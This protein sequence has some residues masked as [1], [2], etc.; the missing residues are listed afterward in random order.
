MF[1]AMKMIRN[2][3][4]VSSLLRNA[5][6]LLLGFC[7][8]GCDSDSNQSPTGNGS[9]I[10]P[11]K[12]G[13]MFIF[14]EEE[15]DYDTGVLDTTFLDTISLVSSTVVGTDI[16]YSVRSSAYQITD[17]IYY[18]DRSDGLWVLSGSSKRLLVKYPAAIGDAFGPDTI[19]GSGTD[20]WAV[21]RWTL[22]AKDDPVSVP[23]GIFTCHKYQK[24][25]I[26][27]STKQL[28]SR[29]INWMAPNTGF[30]LWESYYNDSRLHLVYRSSLL[31]AI[32]K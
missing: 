4:V 32:L 12:V 10:L 17:S 20:A 28:Y 29:Q 2:F 3:G 13:N 15:F 22:V 11:L 6:I 9:Q 24:D 30:V 7:C 27:D 26:V 25:L 31:K 16:F 19:F 8:F 14:Q 5:T 18:Y 21:G 1:V 23:A